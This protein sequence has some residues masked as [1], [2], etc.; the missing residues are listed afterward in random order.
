MEDPLH[1]GVSRFGK[2][3]ER[4]LAD[5]GLI[6]S[7]DRDEADQETGRKVWGVIP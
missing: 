7:R 1:I 6:N 5:H 2:W 4:G 3:G